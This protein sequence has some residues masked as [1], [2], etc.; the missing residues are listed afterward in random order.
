MSYQ[1]YSLKMITWFL[2]CVTDYKASA[3]NVK[4]PW[5][6]SMC[7]MLT[8]KSTDQLNPVTHWALPPLSSLLDDTNKN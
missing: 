6:V 3:L 2:C 5:K 7:Y 8:A 4:T 1:I